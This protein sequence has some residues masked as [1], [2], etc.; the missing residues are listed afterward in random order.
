MYILI[1]AGIIEVIKQFQEIKKYDIYVTGSNAFLL[2]ADLATL[3]TGRYI[4]IHVF[5]FYETIVTR[6]LVQKYALPDTLV[7]QQLS[8]FLMDNISNLTLFGE[9]CDGWKVH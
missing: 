2:S 6:D 3:F 5:P 4:E 8:E 7:L 1:A 9:S